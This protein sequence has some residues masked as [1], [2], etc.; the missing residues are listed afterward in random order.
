MGV[1]GPHP[2][3]TLPHDIAADLNVAAAIDSDGGL[4]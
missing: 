1:I 4:S 3:T 2:D